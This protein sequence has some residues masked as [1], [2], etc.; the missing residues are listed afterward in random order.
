LLGLS[1]ALFCTC[2]NKDV[3]RW[4]GRAADE[5]DDL[6]LN[7]PLPWRIPLA[8]RSVQIETLDAVVAQLDVVAVAASAAD[9]EMVPSPMAMMGVPV[10]AA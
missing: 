5:A 4:R 9:P 3:G 8:K 2:G 6:P 1:G 10:G 7:D